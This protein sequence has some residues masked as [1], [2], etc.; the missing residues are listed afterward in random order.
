[1]RFSSKN[2]II[3]YAFISMIYNNLKVIN[4][5]IRMCLFRETKLIILMLLYIP[6]ST[7]IFINLQ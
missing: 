6:G 2:N 1:V 7:L 5:L 4:E 3:K